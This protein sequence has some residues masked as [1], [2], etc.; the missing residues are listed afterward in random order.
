MSEAGG[1]A[2]SPS[3]SREEIRRRNISG[4]ALT[5]LAAWFVFAP[6][7]LNGFSGRW[8]A[9]AITQ[10]PVV[11]STGGAWRRVAFLG[12]VKESWA[13]GLWVALRVQ[14]SL[15]GDWAPGYHAVSVAA[16]IL[17][18]AFA[19]L[20]C[21]R[22]GSSTFVAGLG[23]LAWAV[24][25]MRA[26]AVSRIAGQGY[27]LGGAAA[28]GGALLIMRAMHPDGPPSGSRL[29]R[30]RNLEGGWAYAVG[31]ILSAVAFSIQPLFAFWPISL[32]L[33]NILWPPPP[34]PFLEWEEPR[35]NF[36][37]LVNRFER[38]FWK[39]LPLCAMGIAFGALMFMAQRSFGPVST[40]RTHEVAQNLLVACHNLAFHLGKTFLPLKLSAFYELPL[41]ISVRNP[42]YAI[43]LACCAVYLVLGFLTLTRLPRMS[44]GLW[45]F[46]VALLPALQVIPLRVAVSDSYTY[47]ASLGLCWAA[48]AGI[49]RAAVPLR[50]RLGSSGM[51][52]THAVSVLALVALALGSLLRQ[53][54]WRDER[55]I[56]AAA[57]RIS[58]KSGEA[59]AVLADLLM[60]EGAKDEANNVI[61]SGLKA[62]P[63]CAEL[64]VAHARMSVAK[65]DYAAALE[66]AAEAVRL[67]PA[68][69]R[70]Q[71]LRIIA[72]LKTGDRDGAAKALET[73]LAFARPAPW[74]LN[75]AGI[76]LLENDMPEHAIECFKRSADAQPLD[77]DAWNLYAVAAS[78]LNKDGIAFRALEKA[79]ALRPDDYDITFNMGNLHMRSAEILER[80]SE[81]EAAERSRQAAK[82]CLER[83]EEL[84]RGKSGNSAGNAKIEDAPSK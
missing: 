27:P 57:I 84:R 17:A 72:F 52:V 71:Q 79:D 64:R 11:T 82:R 65:R 78:K 21:R 73:M 67:D 22:A 40:R 62:A 35:L 75:E 36:T 16:H 49:E 7:L 41:P 3:R 80:N 34:D 61:E 77:A 5:A 23:D 51:A 37:H 15:W 53:F 66:A 26:D 59:S 56:L 31:L 18:A 45:F 58:P 29:G 14:Y 20:L 6:S 47:L 74:L 8:D 33:L 19:F 4:A 39:M 76:A 60:D 28:L 83:A 30:L 13:P 63:Q 55:S 43:A 32:L 46:A 50:D 48:A 10:N 42:A 12:S 25:P 68:N 24:H 44:L 70:A 81:P 69:P 54:D 9:A 1:K 2:A 38:V